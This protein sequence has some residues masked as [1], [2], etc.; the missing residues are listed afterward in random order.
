[1]SCLLRKVV[2]V[3]TCLCSPVIADDGLYHQSV[4]VR[5]P[6]GKDLIMRLDEVARDDKTSTIKIVMISGASVPSAL[7]I[8]EGVYNIIHKREKAYFIKLKE[9]QAEAH[10]TM[11]VVGFSDD[12]TVD[13]TTYFSLSEPLPAKNGYVLQPVKR[14][15]LLFKR[16]SAK[17]NQK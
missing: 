5:N 2:L 6:G 11:M 17:T 14:Y 16:D 4:D 8:A 7:F 1:M 15:D 10:T 12:A 3:L 9:W 13:P